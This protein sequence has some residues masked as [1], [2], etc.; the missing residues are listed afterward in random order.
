[1]TAPVTWAEPKPCWCLVDDAGNVTRA[2][3]QRWHAEIVL[4]ECAAAGVYRR[5]VEYAPKRSR[6]R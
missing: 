5:L 2:F 4:A 1:M 6:R 3:D